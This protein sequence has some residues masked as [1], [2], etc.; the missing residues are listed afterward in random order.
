MLV[1][2]GVGVAGCGVVGSEACSRGC[3]VLCARPQR[4]A[5]GVAA[6]GT[7]E[8]RRLGTRASFLNAR[9]RGGG[10]GEVQLLVHESDARA[11]GRAEEDDAHQRVEEGD[12]RADD[13]AEEDAR[14]RPQTSGEEEEDARDGT[15]PRGTERI[16]RVLL[17]P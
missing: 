14:R 10:G 11:D 6:V 3:R 2:V 17:Q 15:D 1:R 13:R 8:Q 9:S 7:G 12:T 16:G 5:R 4:L